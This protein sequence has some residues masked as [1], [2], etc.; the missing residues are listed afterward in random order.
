MTLLAAGVGYWH[1][2]TRL[3]MGDSYWHVQAPY[4]LES[5]R[6]G[7]GGGGNQITESDW[8]ALGAGWYVPWQASQDPPHPNGVAV[9]QIIR[10][11]GESP[12]LDEETLAAI[13]RANPASVWRIGNEPD[14][15]WQDN[16]APEQYARAYHELYHLVKSVDPTAQVAFGGL[17]QATPLRLLYLDLVWQTYQDLY[18]EEMPVD[19]WVVHNFILPETVT[20]WGAGIPPGMEAYAHLGM[21]YEI[22]DHDDIT[23]FTERIISLRQWMA[24]HGQRDKPLLVPEYGCLMWPVILDEDGNDFSDD[25]VIAFMYATF[26]FFLTATDL[27]LGYPADGNRLVQSWAWY[28]LDDDVFADGQ[29]IGEGYG[30]DLFTGPYTKTMT[31]LGEAYAAYVQPLIGPDYTDLWPLRLQA[32]LTKAVWGQ[33]ATLTV[34]TEV[35]NYGR[36]PAQTVE[37]QFWEGEPGASGTTIGQ[38]QLIA[39]IPGR[40]EG[41]G[42]A[43]V[44]WTTLVSD[45]HSIWVEVDPG[46]DVAE[47]DE[48]NNRGVIA[49]SL[50]VDLSFES[51]SFAPPAPLLESKVVTVTATAVVTNLGSVGV[52]AGVDAWFWVGEPGL[53]EPAE[54]RVLG[55]LAAGEK[56]EVTAELTF[57]TK[58]LHWVTVQLDAAGIIVESDEGNNSVSEVLLVATTHL[59]MPVVMRS[60]G[61]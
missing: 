27:D 16:A 47:S 50:D 48:G 44:A 36:Q 58:G 56:A 19:V 22:R 39:E 23:I 18:G 5:E 17:V 11:Q 55:S 29:K 59:F 31:A 33:T 32:D 38:P 7:V 15:P 21:Q 30:G 51:V 41:T 42:Q 12:V 46:N 57:T 14:S 20:G 24:D 34:T 53:G 1:I 52:P 54:R 49:V 6:F 35:A 28:S 4:P 13:I 26:D 45:T 61:P 8:Q 3:T 40:Y 9:L 60:G 10:I 25:R 43:G 37:V 2:Q